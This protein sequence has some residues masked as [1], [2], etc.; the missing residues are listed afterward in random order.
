MP[1]K[2]QSVSKIL[3][4][5]LDGGGVEESK[6]EGGKES[7]LNYLIWNFFKGGGK[8]IWRGLERF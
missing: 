2:A 8:G 7:R 4:A 3:I 1:P 5:C 6:V